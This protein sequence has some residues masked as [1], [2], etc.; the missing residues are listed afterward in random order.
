MPKLFFFCNIT[1]AY[2][3]LLFIARKNVTDR[4]PKGVTEICICK[5]NVFCGDLRLA[6]FRIQWLGRST[7]SSLDYKNHKILHC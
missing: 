3:F 4:S 6:P 1:D 5:K 2:V 7:A